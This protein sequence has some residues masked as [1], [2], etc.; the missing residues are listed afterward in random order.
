MRANRTSAPSVDDRGPGEDLQHGVAGGMAELVVDLLEVIEIE[1]QHGERLVLGLMTAEQMR[2]A[3]EEGAAVGD[4]AERIDQRIDLVFELGALL[5]HVELKEGQDDR[6]QQRAESDDGLR[7]SLQQRGVVK[8][9][10]PERE[11]HAAEQHRRLRQ[12]HD[13][14]GPT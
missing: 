14:A 8:A 3:L 12:Q 5:G 1:Q 9:I 11:R 6:E 7:Q 4:A 2:G 10:R 13:H